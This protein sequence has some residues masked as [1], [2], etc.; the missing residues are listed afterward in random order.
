[1]QSAANL[2]EAID[3]VAKDY[4]SY[5][6]GLPIRVDISEKEYGPVYRELLALIRARDREIVEECR[7]ALIQCDE[8]GVDKYLF[9]LDK[10]LRDLG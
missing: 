3:K 10:V 2:L 5:E 7:I 4:D 1:M 9:A 8:M 6:Y